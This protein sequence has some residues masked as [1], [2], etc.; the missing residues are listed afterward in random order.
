MSNPAIE[1]RLWR[2]F[3]AVAEELHFGRAAARLHM[4]QPPLTQAIAHLEAL[5]GVRLFE[6]TKRSVQMTAAGAALLPQVLDL[7]RRAQALPEQA[8]AA[9]AGELGRLRLAFVSTAGFSL[10]PKWVRV[11]R[12]RNPLVELE[13]LEATGDMQLQAFE[14]HDID[15]GVILHSPGFAPPGLNSRRVAREPLVLALSEHHRLAARPSLTL[16]QVLAQPLVIFPRR[17]LPSLYDA[18]FAMYHAAAQSP[19][20][21]QEAIQM[22][23]IVNLVSAGLGVAWVPD[24]V[25]QFQ[26]PGVVY[27]RVAGKKG[28]Q[29]PVCET[30]LVWPEGAAPACVTRLIDC[31]PAWPG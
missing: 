27:R 9:A 22:Q 21:V 18:I 10:L 23:T 26:R 19:Q 24:S 16:D 11:F 20:V 29:V 6:R 17:I 14:R 28:R 15:A 3:A 25:R 12:E 7:L 5:L 4:T 8:R 13:L 30:S 1:L 31:A 2:Q